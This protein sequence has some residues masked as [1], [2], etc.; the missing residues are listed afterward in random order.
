MGT[1]TF[2]DLA[3]LLPDL[4]P[5]DLDEVREPPVDELVEAKV[6]GADWGR[7]QLAGVPVRASHLLGVSL[8]GAGWR[9]GTVYGCRFERVDFSG[10]R[11]SRLTIERCEFVGCRMTGLALHDSN[12]KNVVFDDCRLDYANLVAVRGTGAVGWTG[13]TLANA[14]F[15]N[16]QL[17]KAA[18][19]DC[20]LTDLELVDCDLRGTDLRGN[21]LAGIRGLTSLRGTRIGGGQLTGLAALAA[22]ELDIAVDD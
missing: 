16:C 3:V 13:C 21:D 11:M 6:D 14:A 20:R 5:R 1:R 2:G 18:V 17:P 4:D 12:L 10:A 8:A 19:T 9:N 15:T 22:T 7:V